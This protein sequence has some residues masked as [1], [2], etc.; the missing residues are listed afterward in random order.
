MIIE[1]PHLLIDEVILGMSSLYIFKSQSLSPE[2]RAII[3]NLNRYHNLDSFVIAVGKILEYNIVSEEDILDIIST[4]MNMTAEIIEESTLE[5]L[6]ITLQDIVRA[7]FEINFTN[8]NKD[9]VIK[10]IIDLLESTDGKYKACTHIFEA[11]TQYLRMVYPEEE[12]M[13]D[14]A[15]RLSVLC[16]KKARYPHFFDVGALVPQK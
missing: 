7:S 16:I 10:Y 11:I 2:D 3:C 8:E 15:K 14:I 9:F 6:C 12:Y 4:Y 13:K 1:N 5:K